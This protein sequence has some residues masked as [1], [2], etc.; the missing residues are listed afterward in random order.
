MKDP[1]DMTPQERTTF[2]CEMV[3]AV[4]TPGVGS[5]DNILASLEIVGEL[6][7]LLIAHTDDEIVDRRELI[8]RCQ[9]MVGR[10]SNAVEGFGHQ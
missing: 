1:A 2:L 3:F 9:D 8:L 10:I 5:A 7:K 6:H 4:S